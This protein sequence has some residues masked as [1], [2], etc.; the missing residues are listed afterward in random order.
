MSEIDFGNK[1]ATILSFLL[2]FWI[3]S[4]LV[5][6]KFRS[7]E[8]RIPKFL[9]NYISIKK[10]F[11]SDKAYDIKVVQR[12]VLHDGSE[13]L[14]VGVDEKRLLLSKTVQNGLSYLT[15]LDSEKVPSA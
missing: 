15:E 6:N 4:N 14:V 1:L 9:E 3:L 8:W 12:E 5:I 10:N 2:V 13:L 11:G 7:G